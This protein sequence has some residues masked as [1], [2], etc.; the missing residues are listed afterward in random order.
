M[1]EATASL[2]LQLHKGLLEAVVAPTSLHV[3]GAVAV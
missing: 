3:G 2:T 1:T